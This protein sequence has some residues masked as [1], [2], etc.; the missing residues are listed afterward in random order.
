M[1]IKNLA[2]AV[3]LALT[4]GFCTG[5]QMK[6]R[7]VKADQYESV[8]EAQHQTA[9]DI[10]QSMEQSLVVEKAVT[11]STNNVAA[12]KKAVIKRIKKR[13]QSN[14]ANL[15]P[16]CP[17]TS[18]DVSTVRL[19]NDAR[20]G[21]TPDAATL[22]DAEGQAASGLALSELLENDLE[23]VSQ[24]HDLSARHNALVDYVE[25]QIK[26]QAE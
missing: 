20:A 14:D 13:E 11:D 16:L 8:I 9:Q 24:Y 1:S 17:A 5:Y 10:Q 23:V 26:K 18:F 2:L 7:F 19:L 25:A 3:A 4:F 21:T 6:S 22:N 12:I 15:R